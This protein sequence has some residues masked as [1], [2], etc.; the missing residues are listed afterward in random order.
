MSEAGRSGF[1]TDEAETE[2]RLL[3]TEHR[4]TSESALSIDGLP[5]GSDRSGSE[6]VW[7]SETR[8]KN[9][10]QRLF[11]KHPVLNNTFCCGKNKLKINTFLFLKSKS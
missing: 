10:D 3:T 9:P 4:F 1:G 5:P 11:D 2:S 8:N 6:M 7:S